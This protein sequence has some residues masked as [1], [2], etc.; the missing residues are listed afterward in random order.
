MLISSFKE[1]IETTDFKVWKGHFYFLAAFD[2]IF[3]P[4]DL[5]EYNLAMLWLAPNI[6]KLSSAAKFTYSIEGK[7]GII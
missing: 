4:P 7:D 1:N 5:V 6:G 3:K 2:N